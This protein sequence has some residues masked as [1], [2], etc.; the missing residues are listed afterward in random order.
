MKEIRKLAD[1]H[2]ILVIEDA[3]QAV[4]C[5]ID[6]QHAGTFGHMSVFSF[7]SHKNITTLGEGDVSS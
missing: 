4:G 7:H 5:R 1:A 2:G 3:A 6:D